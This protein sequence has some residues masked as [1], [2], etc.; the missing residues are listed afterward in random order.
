VP[1]QGFRLAVAGLDEGWLAVGTDAPEGADGDVAI[2]H[3]GADLEVTRVPLAGDLVGVGAQAVT[4][5]VTRG[6]EVIIT[7]SFDGGPAIWVLSLDEV[8]S[9]V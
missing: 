3:V 1:R 5:V 2:W 4:S 8:L 6:D 9:S 7:G